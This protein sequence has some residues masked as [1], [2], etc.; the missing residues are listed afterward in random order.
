ML[1]HLDPSLLSA[2]I[3]AKAKPL[4]EEAFGE[5]LD[6]ARDN[7]IRNKSIRSE[8]LID[9]LDVKVEAKYPN[10]R[11]PFST[12]RGYV[13][14]NMHETKVVNGKLKDPVH[15]APIVEYGGTIELGKTLVGRER[16]GKR[17]RGKNIYDVKSY[18]YISP[19]PFLRPA[20]AS[21]NLKSK[22]EKIFENVAK[23][24]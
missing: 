12:I 10:A 5:V 4:I 24:I 9:S 1:A 17:G 6:S 22:I 19:K 21:A 8:A 20:V 3:I 16:T 11:Y 14:V 23:E 7:L 13:G 2:E 18:S 15:Y